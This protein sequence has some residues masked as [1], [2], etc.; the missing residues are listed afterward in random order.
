MAFFRVFIIFIFVCLF[1]SCRT[2]VSAANQEFQNKRIIFLGDSITNNGL[3]VSFIEYHFFKAGINADVISV[4]LS[5]ETASGLSEKKCPFP[6][7]CIHSR[8]DE[9]LA[10]TNPD[11]VVVCYGM[12]DGIYHP[13]NHARMLAY[14]LGIKKLIDTVQKSGSEIILMTPPPF[15]PKPISHKTKPINFGDFSYKNPLVSYNEVLTDYADWLVSLDYKVIDQNKLLREY[16]QKRRTLTPEF[17][18]SKDGIHPDSLGHLLMAY[19]FLDGMNFKLKDKDLNI[20][21]NEVLKLVHE[22]RKLRSKA[23][24]E[25][26]GYTRGKTVKTDSVEDKET[27]AAKLQEEILEEIALS[28]KPQ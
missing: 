10:K 21:E 4:G 27:E 3:Y 22:R 15:D 18:L 13:Q 12:N 14:Q 8:L 5:G 23:W 2:S 26:I 7:P 20:E 28:R 24:L 16:I 1:S 6:R 11:I 17:T 25:Y 19:N 9:V